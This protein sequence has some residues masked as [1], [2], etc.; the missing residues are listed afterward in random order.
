M[1]TPF[2]RRSVKLWRA[3]LFLATVGALSGCI[4]SYDCGMQAENDVMS[5][6]A[7]QQTKGTPAYRYCID[8]HRYKDFAACAKH[9]T[10]D[11]AQ[12]CVTKKAPRPEVYNCLNGKGPA[13]VQD[14]DKEYAKP[15]PKLHLEADPKPASK[16]TGAF[17]T[18]IVLTAVGPVLGLAVLS[19]GK[20]L[21]CDDEKTDED[22]KNCKATKASAPTGAAVYAGLGVGIGVPLML[23]GLSQKQAY[24][25][26]SERHPE[27][28]AGLRLN[29]WP[30]SRGGMAAA[31][32]WDLD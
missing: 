18:G 10:K 23:H 26:W 2:L 32:T 24:R 28:Q 21:N 30:L 14:K 27:A 31:L 22:K 9:A 16:G 8:N 17:V 3:V 13:L 25:E 4:T 6:Q 11:G 20:S 12:S 1:L 15:L 29:L 5:F 7:C 19:Y